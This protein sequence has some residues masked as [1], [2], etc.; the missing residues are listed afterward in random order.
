MSFPIKL[1]SSP[2]DFAGEH[3]MIAAMFSAGLP[4]L[5]LRKPGHTHARL[6]RWLLALE[7]E[8]RPFVIVHGHPDLALGMGLA[9]CHMPLD[10][11][12]QGHHE[13]GAHA[14]ISR[15]SV[16]LHSLEEL[17]S[18]PA[19]I[20][21]AFL[22]PIF[23]SLSKPGYLSAFSAQE[24]QAALLLNHA[25]RQVGPAVYALGGIEAQN[26]GMVA[27]WGFGGAAVLGAVWNAP[28]PVGALEEILVSAKAI[29]V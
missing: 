1:V 12:R 6:E 8:W 9:G 11:L 22:S 4:C 27:E 29:H 23:D 10:W 25:R 26:L 14:E 7:A 24:L 2:E 20:G 15:W 28:D 16:S 19:G 5:Q 21:E 3:E 18:C 17:R 13:K